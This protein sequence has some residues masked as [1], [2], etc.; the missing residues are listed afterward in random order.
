MQVMSV[1][2]GIV[3]APIDDKTIGPE[4]ESI[5]IPG[6]RGINV[7]GSG[8]S[9][10]WDMTP[11]VPVCAAPLSGD[12]APLIGLQPFP[13]INSQQVSA[14]GGASYL[15]STN[16]LAPYP[17]FTDTRAFEVVVT[18]MDSGALISTGVICI[19]DV[20]KSVLVSYLPTYNGGSWLFSLNGAVVG[21]FV[22]SGLERVGIKVNGAT[23]DCWFY[24]N[25]IERA[26][27]VGAETTDVVLA[28]AWN[29]SSSALVDIFDGEIIT[30]F[31]NMAH[32]YGC[33]DWCGNAAVGGDAV[34]PVGARAGS[35]YEVS[36]PGQYGGDN[37]SL[38]DLA[39]VRID[40]VSV[41]RV[42]PGMNGLSAYQVAV[43]NGFA[44]TE[45]QWLDS[46]KGEPG[47]DGAP[48]APGADGAPGSDGSPGADGAPGA[49]GL[50]SYQVA[51]ANGFFGT[52]AQWLASLVGPQGA[53]GATGPQGP[54]G[55]GFSR[56]TATITTA[57]IAVNSTAQGTVSLSKSFRVQSLATDV[58]ARVRLYATAAQRDA[59][60]SRAIGTAPSGNHG[61]V[62]E[63][64]TGAGL[65]SLM[66]SPQADG[67]NLDASPSSNIPYNV[68]NIGTSTTAINVTLGYMPTES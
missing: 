15:A 32:D 13:T 49:N 58:P 30:A 23:G 42:G 46:L 48:G 31:S 63:V 27:G 26:I 3:P 7:G 50:S 64:I 34:L 11:P 20:S 66:M 51:V 55:S 1:G 57:S 44:G 9:G 52:E 45:L 19:N 35:I 16:Y 60:A 22:G 37:F 47:A 38:G 29:G 33:H 36:V 65:L 21:D 6:P 67:S 43:A 39:V 41:T 62:M 56:A 68:T 25:G 61:L 17:A 18:R 24:I 54:T 5:Y 40:G 10:Y 2:L 14:V 8:I 4:V 53:Q 59:D 12:A 28:I